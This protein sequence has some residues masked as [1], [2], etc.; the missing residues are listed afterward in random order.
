ML[1]QCAA[2]AALVCLAAALAAQT[3]K[4]KSVSD[5]DLGFR[6]SFPSAPQADSKSQAAATGPIE[7]HSYCAQ[8]KETSLCVAV[9]VH[10]PEATGLGPEL[11]LDRIKQGVLAGDKTIKISETPIELDGHKGV[12]LETDN[13]FIHTSTRI[14]LVGGLVYQTMVTYPVAGKYAETVRFLDSFHLIQRAQK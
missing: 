7:F 6:A 12:A 13:P 10:G 1:R 3:S 11:F 4:W 2:T 8:V 5:P 9:F 14:F